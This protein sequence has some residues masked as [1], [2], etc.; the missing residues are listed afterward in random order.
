MQGE[1]PILGLVTYDYDNEDN[2]SEVEF[3]EMKQVKIGEEEAWY[4][5]VNGRQDDVERKG[6][7]KVGIEEH[8][9]ALSLDR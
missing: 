2:N 3:E 1:H 8:E 6:C 4:D 5:M 7:K 9:K